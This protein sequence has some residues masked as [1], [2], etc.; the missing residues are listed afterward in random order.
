MSGR[1][2]L[3]PSWLRRRIVLRQLMLIVTLGI[4]VAACSAPPAGHKAAPPSSASRSTTSTTTAPTTT[5]S[6]AP[7]TTT[8][9]PTTQPSKTEGSLPA[10]TS[11]TPTTS[12]PENLKQLFG[13]VWQQIPTTSRVV[14]LTFDAGANGNGVPAILSTLRSA[15]VPATFFLTGG[16]T[17]SFPD[18][19]RSIVQGGYRVGDHTVDHPHLPT[20]SDAM[21]AAEVADAAAT[22]TSATGASPV[23]L[24][25]FPYGDSDARTLTVVNDLGYVAVGWTVDTLGWEGSSAGITAASIVARVIAGLRPGEIVLMHVGSNPNDGSTLDA[26]ALASVIGSIKA[27]GYSFVT[28]DALVGDG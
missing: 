11:T 22:I 12:T 6:I 8:V 19:A 27:A 24:F 20:L 26:D 10:T 17:K 14:A 4:L 23:P 28:L 21:A 2:T 25:R 13:K 1:T 9:A 5:T 3:S 18:L 7:T 15:G 16:F